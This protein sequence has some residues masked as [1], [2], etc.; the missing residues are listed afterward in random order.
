MCRFVFPESLYSVQSPPYSECLLNDD[1]PKILDKIYDS[2]ERRRD[3]A[4]GVHGVHFPWTPTGKPNRPEQNPSI[5]CIVFGM[6]CPRV[7]IRPKSVSPEQYLRY[8][9][10]GCPFRILKKK[11]NYFFSS[12]SSQSEMDT[13]DHK[14]ADPRGDSSILAKWTPVDTPIK[15]RRTESMDTVRGVWIFREVSTGNGWG[16]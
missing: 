15:K 13:P 6:G 10:R 14:N 1:F 2:I 4:Q 16:S 9:V 12:L 5:Q 11:I 8:G 3:M 7:S